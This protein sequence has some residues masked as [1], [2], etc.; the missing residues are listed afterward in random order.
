VT[1]ATFTIPSPPRFDEA[2][3]PAYLSSR[4]VTQVRLGGPMR[5]ARLTVCP[6]EPLA[7]ACTV[8]RA[9]VLLSL[10][11]SITCLSVFQPLTRPNHGS[12]NQR[13][14]Y[15]RRQG[16]FA[17]VDVPGWLSDFE[18]HL[19]YATG[20]T[21]RRWRLRRH[22]WQ[23]LPREGAYDWRI[24]ATLTLSPRPAPEALTDLVERVTR[25]GLMFDRG[26]VTVNY[27]R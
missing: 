23:Y 22:S 21:N 10:D 26:V 15:A 12:T 9:D 2:F 3:L 24:R 1:R 19:R 8:Y 16:E 25:Y 11:D 4:V 18:E 27:H 14:A 7:D 13:L 6:G 5:R 17:Y 20:T